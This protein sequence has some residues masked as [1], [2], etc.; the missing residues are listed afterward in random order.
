MMERKNKESNGYSNFEGGEEIARWDEM[1]RNKGR[2][3]K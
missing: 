3:V 2:R 1:A